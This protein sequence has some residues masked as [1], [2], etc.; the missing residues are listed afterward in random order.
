MVTFDEQH[1]KVRLSLRQADI[2]EALAKDEK[3]K[4]QGGCVPDLET[5][6]RY[7]LSLK[8]MVRLTRVD[9]EKSFLS[10]TLNSAGSCWR[11]PLVSLGVSDLKTC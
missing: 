8:V 9:M 1:R 2:L 4:K 7:V 5:V 10:F 6:V 11:P 3:L